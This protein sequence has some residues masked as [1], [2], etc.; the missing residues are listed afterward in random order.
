M[1]GK[2]DWRTLC[3]PRDPDGFR[4][5]VLSAQIFR[6]DNFVFGQSG[7]G[8]N[9]SSTDTKARCSHPL[10]LVGVELNP[11]PPETRAA[12]DGVAFVR[13]DHPTEADVHRIYATLP[14]DPSFRTT[15]AS[16]YRAAFLPIDLLDQ[17]WHV[18][19]EHQWQTNPDYSGYSSKSFRENHQGRE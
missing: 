5:L 1:H 9:W 8:N 6:S 13:V 12:E 11:G 7:A 17:L 16:W 15:Y 2:S 19:H 3:A 10:S 14:T 18:Y 4:A